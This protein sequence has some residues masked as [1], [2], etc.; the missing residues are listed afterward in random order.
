[1]PTDKLF[2]CITGPTAQLMIKVGNAD[3]PLIFMGQR[4]YGVKQNHGVHPARNGREDFAIAGGQ[5]AGL[6]PGFD[7]LEKIAHAVILL[8][9]DAAGKQAV[10]GTDIALRCPR[11]KSE[12][13]GGRLWP[14]L[15]AVAP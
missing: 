14:D 7:A 6:H 9:L 12:A 13:E 5:S 3:Q 4:M 10:D 11:P 8:F 2:I 15:C 1:R